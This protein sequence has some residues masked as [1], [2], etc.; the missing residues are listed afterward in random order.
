MNE[1]NKAFELLLNNE[2]ELFNIKSFIEIATV[3]NLEL[4]SKKIEA[5]EEAF[6]GVISNL[7]NILELASSKLKAVRKT[8]LSEFGEVDEA[9]L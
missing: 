5:S 4:K 1:K 2:S 6:H 3:Y 8:L 7:D 9:T